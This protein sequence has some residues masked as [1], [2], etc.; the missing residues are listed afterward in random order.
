MNRRIRSAVASASKA[1]DAPCT[2][3]TAQPVEARLSLFDKL[4]FGFCMVGGFGTLIVG[5]FAWVTM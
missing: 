5:L 3:S 4:C 2:A 1:F